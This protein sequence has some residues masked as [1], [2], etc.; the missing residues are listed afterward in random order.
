MNIKHDLRVPLRQEK[1][2]V[3]AKELRQ[4][5]LFQPIG[6]MSRYEAK[7]YRIAAHRLDMQIVR[8]KCKTGK[9]VRIWRV[10]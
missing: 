7:K 10:Q 3:Q 6:P 5:P 2:A 1:R 4:T 9:K 8:R